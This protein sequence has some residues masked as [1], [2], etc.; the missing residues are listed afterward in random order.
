MGGAVD[1]QRSFGK[2]L[3]SMTS[4]IYISVDV[5]TDGPIPGPNSMLSIG[6]AS[7]TPDGNMLSTFSSN[8]YAMP[9]SN[10]D[11]DTAR[12]WL[13]HPEAW[14]EVCRDRQ[15]PDKAMA[16][17][18]EWVTKQPGKPVFVGYPAGF[19]FLFVYWYLIKFTGSSPFSFSALDMK[20]YA[21]AVL[22]LP[23]R[24]SVKKNFPKVWFGHDKHSHV[25]VEDAIEQGRIFCKML[26][27]P[28]V[29]P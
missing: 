17:F 19:D 24:D 29:K 3:V 6:A 1:Q 10:P 28:R 14:A 18:K 12:W 13:S 25:A 26:K 22:G 20:T 5:E 27:H 21:M 2:S 16:A 11:P 9:G 7:F 8:I 15:E 4:E 23:Y